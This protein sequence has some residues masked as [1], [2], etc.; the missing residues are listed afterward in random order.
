MHNFASGGYL[1]QQLWQQINSFVL[2]VF[3]DFAG[4]FA[5]K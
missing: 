4:F 3:E 1:D 2:H 5:F